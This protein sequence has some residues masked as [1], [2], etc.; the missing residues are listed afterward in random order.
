VTAPLHLTLQAGPAR[1]GEP[2]PVT[3]RLANAGG[4]PVPAVGVLDGSETGL[5]YPY[6]LPVVRRGADVVARPGPPEDPMVRPLR[7]V[8][9]VTLQP[10][11]SLDPTSSAGGG[12][13]PLSTFAT[14]RAATPGRHTFELTLDTRAPSPERWL[15]RFGQGSERDAVLAL[16]ARVPAVLLTASV[17]VDVGGG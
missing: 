1:A 10:G 6:W 16:V 14:F 15:G 11:D 3:V 5:R 2:V 17:D 4:V 13:L 12:Y 7:A 8:D 9:V